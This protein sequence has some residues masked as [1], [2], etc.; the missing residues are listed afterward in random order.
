MKGAPVEFFK[1][2]GKTFDVRVKELETLYKEIL[3]KPLDFTRAESY[4][5][6]EDKKAFPANEAARR[7]DW[8]KYLKYLTLQ[9]YVDLIDNRESN[10][11]KEGAVSK[12]DAELEKE[13]RDKVLATMNRTFERYRNKFTEEDK[14]NVFVNVITE[15]MDPHTEFMPPLDKRYFDETMSGKFYGIGAQLTYDDGNIKI[16]SGLQ[17]GHAQK[18]A[19]VEAGDIIVRV[20][21]ATK[22]PVELSGFAIKA[23]VKM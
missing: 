19:Q 21:Q 13:A 10:K 9:R 4:I 3:S 23:G 17:G 8:R 5:G 6:D 22:S 7:E 2:A 16:A 12:A 15:M 1:E 18:C 20:A 14:F 11:G